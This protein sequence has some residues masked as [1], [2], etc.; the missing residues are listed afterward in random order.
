MTNN[1][2]RCSKN[3]KLNISVD[4]YKSIAM[5]V[6]LS[7][8]EFIQYACCRVNWKKNEWIC[9]LSI[10]FDIKQNLGKNHH[11]ASQL[12]FEINWFC[13]KTIPCVCVSL[14]HS[15]QPY[16]DMNSCTLQSCVLL[17]P[18]IVSLFL[19]YVSY[20]LRIILLVQ[21]R[22]WLHEVANSRIA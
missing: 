5:S 7:S 10:R 4:E 6:H 12:H 15:N 19:P 9:I 13:S 11:H 18:L 2:L 20:I 3:I 17:H 21:K 22:R 14:F 16:F 1:D 8:A